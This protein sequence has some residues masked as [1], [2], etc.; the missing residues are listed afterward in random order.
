MQRSKK[1][2]QNILQRWVLMTLLSSQY[3][4]SWFVSRKVLT[5]YSLHTTTSILG[6]LTA[7]VFM[8]LKWTALT[9]LC[10]SKF[11]IFC[12]FLSSLD[13]HNFFL[14]FQMRPLSWYTAASTEARELFYVQMKAYTLCSSLVLPVIYS[15]KPAKQQNF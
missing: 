10:I 15:I 2:F 4:S 6:I 11:Y 5:Y 14:L 9:Y 7:D 12:I 13:D 3:C 1:V 8:S